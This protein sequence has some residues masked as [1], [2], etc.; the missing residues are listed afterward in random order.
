MGGLL[1]T[2]PVRPHLLG[3]EPCYCTTLLLEE[4]PA[5]EGRGHSSAAQ[6]E[7]TN[8]FLR[9]E[10]AFS[11][12]LLWGL[13]HHLPEAEWP[14][15]ALEGRREAARWPRCLPSIITVNQQHAGARVPAAGR[16]P[17]PLRGE[18]RETLRSEQLPVPA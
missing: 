6:R 1:N 3:T 16:L 4:G 11:I 18:T 10:R 8:T 17:P 7:K 15:P 2:Y 14:E 9:K 12:L 5:P 13:G